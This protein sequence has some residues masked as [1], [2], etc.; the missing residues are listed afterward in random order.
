MVLS[1][2]TDLEIYFKVDRVFCFVF[3]SAGPYVKYGEHSIF[4]ETSIFLLAIDF[5]SIKQIS[6]SKY[7]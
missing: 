2:P 7:F 3:S 4:S 6:F 5:D 1:R